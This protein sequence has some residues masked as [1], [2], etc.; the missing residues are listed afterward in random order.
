MRPSLMWNGESRSIDRLGAW[1]DAGHGDGLSPSFRR[2]H[3]DVI[4]VIMECSTCRLGMPRHPRAPSIS[5]RAPHLAHLETRPKSLTCM[6]VNGPKN[7]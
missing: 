3:G 2:A 5:L 6:R 7:P 1:T 4:V